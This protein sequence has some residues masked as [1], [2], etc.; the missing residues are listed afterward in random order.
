M[1]LYTG[2]GDKG[3][4]SVFGCRIKKTEPLIGAI[5]TVDELNS[6]IG[7]CRENCKDNEVDS[8]LKEVQRKLFVIGSDLAG[9][10]VKLT[11][12]DMSWLQTETDKIG[13][14]TQELKN[15][16][17]PAGPA[18]HLQYARAL[19]RKAEIETWKVKCNT[20]IQKFLNRLSSLLFGMALLYNKKRNWEEDNWP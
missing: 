8:I 14:K 18:S 15:F 3:D 4:T 13:A 5:G 6:Y 16:V 20:L 12:T 9:G 19:A 11:E 2:T 10:N 7:V 1:K 17:L